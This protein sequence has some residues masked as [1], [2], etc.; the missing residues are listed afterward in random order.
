VVSRWS[1]R[2]RLVVGLT[3]LAVIGLIVV[4]VVVVV[5]LRAYLV[6]GVDD[7]LS[8]AGT[9]PLSGRPQGPQSGP[10]QPGTGVLGDD[11]TPDQRLPST[12][13]FERLDA[14]G[15]LLN[16]DF[17]SLA[18]GSSAP[19]L[20]GLT[21]A[22]AKAHGDKIFTV[23]AKGGGSDYR[24]RARAGDDG[25]TSIIAISLGGVDSTLR[26]LAGLTAAVSLAAVL[27]L[28]VLA[29]V[30]VR[31]GLKPLVAV[32]DTAEA[33]AAGDL[34]R[35]VPDGPPGTEVGRLSTS[36]N[37]MLGQIE[38]SFA[39]KD[40]AERRLR[41]F[42]AD[43]GH[44]LRTPLTSIRGYAELFRQGAIAEPADQTRAMGRIESEAERM[45][46]LVDD[47]LLLARLDQQRPLER[48]PVELSAMARDAVAD[49]RVRDPGRAIDLEGPDS[50]VVVTGDPDRL[51]QVLDN[52]LGNALAHTPPS[53]PVHVTLAA[54]GEDRVVLAVRDEGPGMT[55]EQSARVFERFYRADP[56]RSRSH[57]GSGLG[58]SIVDAVVTSHGGSVRCE[59]EPGVGTTFTMVLPRV[60]TPRG[61]P[62]VGGV[63]GGNLGL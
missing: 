29:R 25:T 62:V 19:D 55:P 3:V 26:S 20:T 30:V 42:V 15:K 6:R 24:V 9:G 2:T 45:G 10:G 61:L 54:E 56:S 7:Q 40:A 44:E 38:T 27:L 50:D 12:F 58:L 22:A 33:I 23:P 48:V 53:T 13:V 47:L 59:S 49:A 5:L 41:R 31:V 21:T 46:H 17:G 57:G 37:T 32:E 34:S 52:L 39:E 60:L 4:N 11:S 36:L 35:R 8:G 14:S 43:A 18:P 1:L 63:G 16:Q 51:R 28:A